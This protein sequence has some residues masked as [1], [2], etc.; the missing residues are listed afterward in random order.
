VTIRDNGRGIPVGM[1]PTENKPA[2]ELVM[3]VLHAGGKFNQDNYKVSGGLHGVGVSAVNA[4]SDWLRLEIWRDGYAWEQEYARG[5]PQTELKRLASTSE[6]GTAVTFHPDPMIFKNIVAFNY[7][8]LAQK[9]RELAYLNSGL[10]ITIRDERT[11]RTQEFRYEGGIATFVADMNATNAVIHPEVI[12]F[13]SEHEGVTVDVALQWN[14]SYKRAAR[15]LHQHDQE[16]RR[17]HPPDRLPPGPD[18]DHQQL[19]HRV[20]APRQG[21]QGRD[22][23]GRRSARGPDRGHLGQ[24]VGPEVLE[25]GQGQAGVERGRDR[26]RRGGGGQAERVPGAGVVTIT[27]PAI[28]MSCD[29]LS[30]TS[31]VPGGRSQIR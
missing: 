3:T 10:T 22:P 25:P 24:G 28:G 5:I 9:L 4:L 6:R 19:R 7:E 1:H 21:R 27:E 14:E 31:P 26:G 18:P 2:A 16:P 20:Q 11:E 17:R 30:W 12:A 23:V 29:R 13:M 15:L 8:Q